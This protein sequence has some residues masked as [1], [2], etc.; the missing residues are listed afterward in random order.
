MNSKNLLLLSFILGLYLIGCAAAPP[1]WVKPGT[2]EADLEAAMDQCDQRHVAS[3]LGIHD[4][5]IR[6]DPLINPVRGYGRGASALARD[7]C[8]EKQGWIY[9]E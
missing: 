8:L 4:P 9:Q 2:T 7:L 6:E 3:R 5:F 1:L